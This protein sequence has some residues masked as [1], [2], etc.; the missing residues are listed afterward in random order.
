[1]KE[2]H[3][4]IRN[5]GLYLAYIYNESKAAYIWDEYYR[6][7]EEFEQKYNGYNKVFVDL[8]ATEGL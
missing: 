3:F 6:S 8:D 4:M 5:D 1:M 7:K 2:V